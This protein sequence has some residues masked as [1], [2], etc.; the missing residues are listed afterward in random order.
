MYAHVAICALSQPART[1]KYVM[2]V[3]R[4]ELMIA[5]PTTRWP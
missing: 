1:A 3:S 4:G 2:Y 5:M